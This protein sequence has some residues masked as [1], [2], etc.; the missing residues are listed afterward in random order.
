MSRL[1]RLSLALGLTGIGCAPA[2]PAE[3]VVK[4]AIEDVPAIRVEAADAGGFYR[5]AGV[6]RAARRAELS[7]RLLGRVESVR[8]R[9]GDRVRAGQLLLTVE[10]ASLSA[11]E[12]Q[13][14]SA[15][16]L[17]TTN[18]RRVE[19]L[20]ADS[21]APL[22]QLEAARNAFAQAEGQVR[23]VRADLAYADL[24]APFDGTVASRLVDP[25]D[26]AA[27]G[28]PLL[29]VEDRGQREIV[30]TM[31]DELRHRVRPGQAVIVEIGDGRRRVTAR[32]TAEVSGA[33]LRSPTIELRLAGPFD[34][35][36]GIAAVAEIP[37]AERTALL[38][39]AGA[40]VERGQLQGV[41]LFAPDSTLRLRW[42]R[43]GRVR[44]DSVEVVSGLRAGDLLALDGA[45]ARDGLR[46]R[47][48]LPGGPD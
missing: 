48:L 27:P 28:Q 2:E 42:I 34:L 39:P 22:V 33:D 21:A 11:A 3:R 15:L 32:V 7:T 29:V 17:A 37:T 40:V 26:H 14:A 30:V 41:Y 9:A 12:R 47:P 6:V 18:L 23:S 31:P 46:A 36:P 20:Y 16:D 13:A 45:R 19:R 38:V 25:G 24:R 43:A 8:V 10:R 1:S 35:T 4:S 5:A 44:G